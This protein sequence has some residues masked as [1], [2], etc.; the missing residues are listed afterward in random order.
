M[1]ELGLREIA[2]QHRDDCL[3]MRDHVVELEAE[4]VEGSLAVGEQRV[5]DLEPASKSMESSRSRVTSA[6]DVGWPFTSRRISSQRRMPASI[7]SAPNQVDDATRQRM[8]ARLCSSPARR[9]WSAARSQAS[10]AAETRPCHQ[11][12]DAWSCRARQSPWWCARSQNGITLLRD[13]T[14]TFRRAD[15]GAAKLEELILDPQPRPGVVVVGGCARPS[16]R[17]ARSRRRRAHLRP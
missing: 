14:S 13:G 3:G 9:A 6:S 11:A 5:C 4:V 16:R 12:A 17:R 15:D 2:G 1:L 10:A 7:G 8:S